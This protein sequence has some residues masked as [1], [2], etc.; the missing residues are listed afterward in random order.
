MLQRRLLGL[1]REAPFQVM[2]TVVLALCATARAVGQALVIA[3]ILR[4]VFQQAPLEGL[5]GLAVAAVA[6]VAGRASLLLRFFD[7]SRA[8]SGWPGWTCVSC[9]W[10]PAGRCARGQ[11]GRLPVPRSVAD[12]LRLARPG[13]SD[14]E[15]VAAATA[16]IAHEFIAVLPAGYETMIGERGGHAVRR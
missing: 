14:D 9:R 3:T 16:A 5:Y 15:I 1:V 4:R 2:L 8:A 11:P 6:L 12:N 7:P 13:A 10:R